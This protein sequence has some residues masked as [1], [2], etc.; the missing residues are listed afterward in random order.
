MLLIPLNHKGIS[1]QLFIPFGATAFL[2]D[3]AIDLLASKI[4]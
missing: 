3:L 2:L 1:I 4:N